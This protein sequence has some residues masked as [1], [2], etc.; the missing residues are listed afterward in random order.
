MG[1]VNR[2]PAAVLGVLGLLTVAA[3]SPLFQARFIDFDDDT[4]VYDN[5]HIR[6]GLNPAA[7]RWAFTTFSAGNWH[8]LTWL[9]HELDVTLFGRE[10]LGHHLTS[11]GL[12]VA[13]TG[14]MFVLIL[15]MTGRMA[16]STFVAAL[17]AIHPLHVESVA[18]ISERKD[19]LSS[20]FGLLSLTTYLAWARTTA[21]RW[22]VLSVLAFVASLL[23]KP[24]LVT[25]PFL[26]LLLDFWPLGRMPPPGKAARTGRGHEPPPSRLLLEKIPFL[27]LAAASSVT[28]L[29][30][31]HRGG[32]FY[33]LPFNWRL[34]NAT[35]AYG[36]YL[37]KTVWPANLT[38]FY[39]HLEERAFTGGLVLAIVLL[40]GVS[41]ISLLFA[42]RRPWLFV[43]WCWYLGMLVPVIGLVQ[44][45]NQAYADRYTYLP[46]VGIFL[47]FALTLD[48]SFRSQRLRTIWG[49]LGALA[50]VTLFP[51][52]ARQVSFWQ[53]SAV[54]F[55]HMLAA[56]DGNWIAHNGVGLTLARAR[57]FEEAAVRFR[58]AVRL[59]PD[60]AMGWANLGNA[61]IGMRNSEAVAA[62]EEAIRLQP[63]YTPAY[64]GLVWFYLGTGD[65]ASAE[66][67]VPRLQ[68]ANLSEAM[69]LERI[70]APFRRPGTRR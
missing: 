14:L 61:L 37:L 9:S 46:L 70:I 60:F 34:G 31:Q 68:A 51:V 57:R 5:P 64:S 44:V 28:T 69:A 3:Y 25:L 21:R 32:M 41:L 50:V 13:N 4:Y 15:A 8:P 27:L 7:M 40:V 17:F 62:M 36:R 55:D 12:H 1:I 53:N 23:A 10:P 2:R 43:G 11:L 30:V 58:E 63:D 22:Y 6:G 49:C 45:G 19:V 38:A 59:R 24:M 66:A 20:F 42:Q 33:H 48:H 56:T 35:L 18:W 39:P 65:V 67:V 47:G 26:L 52:T 16:P 29:V 54:F